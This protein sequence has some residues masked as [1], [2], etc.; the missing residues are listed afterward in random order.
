MP[1]VINITITVGD[2]DEFESK[3]DGTSV[4]IK[5]GGAPVE[6]VCQTCV[7]NARLAREKGELNSRIEGESWRRWP[8]LAGRR[9][10]AAKRL[11]L[12]KE[13]QMSNLA[14]MD[15]GDSGGSSWAR[16]WRRGWE[17]GSKSA[18][19]QAVADVSRAL[20]YDEDRI[21]RLALIG[22]RERQTSNQG[23]SN[24][25]IHAD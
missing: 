3:R 23:E 15:G 4:T 18:Y 24:V 6:N 5:S 11:E 22:E 10:P 1:S 7:Q 9:R 19:S 16:G 2:K 8:L 14:V 13:R 25:G 20:G 12:E 21:R 17:S